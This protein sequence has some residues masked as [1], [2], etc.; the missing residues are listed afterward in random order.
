MTRR[1]H[2]GAAAALVVVLAAV[3][4]CSGGSDDRADRPSTTTTAL[5]A[6]RT[7][8]FAVADLAAVDQCALLSVAEA[9]NLLHRPAQL[10][11][12]ATM[13]NAGTCTVQA[14]A[15]PLA[16]VQWNVGVAKVSAST[17]TRW[18]A[19]VEADLEEGAAPGTCAPFDRQMLPAEGLG[20]G[21]TLLTCGGAARTTYELAAS[22][23]G[24]PLILTVT[25]APDQAGAQDVVDAA[26]LLVSR[27]PR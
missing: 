13:G 25:R 15:P 8:S 26:K 1:L 2:R 3:G 24:H 20:D 4:A 10:T 5:A 21:A 27:L 22:T 14:T 17:Y 6:P 23:G 18:L 19:N 9:G 7:P 11:A 12:Q 16:I